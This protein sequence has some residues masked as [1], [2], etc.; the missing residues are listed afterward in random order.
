MGGGGGGEVWR[1]VPR[2]TWA[3]ETFGPVSE[4]WKSEVSLYLFFFFLAGRLR[5]SAFYT[6]GYRIFGLVV[7]CHFLKL[8]LFVEL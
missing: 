5:V 7:F 1:I 3:S 4:S 8:L 2:K 6:E